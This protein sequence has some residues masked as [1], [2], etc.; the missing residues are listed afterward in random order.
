MEVEKIK[1]SDGAPVVR[2]DTLCIHSD[3]PGAVDTAKA[4]RKTLEHAGVAIRPFA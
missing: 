2:A 4:V 3:S 1:A